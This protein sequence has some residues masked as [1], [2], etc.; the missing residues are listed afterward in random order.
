[1]EQFE[2]YRKHIDQAIEWVWNIIPNL[3]TAVVLLVVGFW[4]IKLINK[5]TMLFQLIF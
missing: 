4:V 1:M 2:S 3:V 5:A